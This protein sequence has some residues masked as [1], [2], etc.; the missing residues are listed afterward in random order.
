LFDGAAW[1]SFGAGASATFRHAETAREWTLI[2][3][4]RMR[5]CRGGEEQVAIASGRLRTT[6]GAGAR[7]GAEVLVFTPHGVLRYGDASLELTVERRELRTLA[8]GGQVWLETLEGKAAVLSLPL[9]KPQSTKGKRPPAS[10]EQRCE[11]LAQRASEV[12]GALTSVP[13]AGPGLSARAVE[14][15]RARRDARFACGA[16]EAFAGGLEP[17]ERGR[18]LD[19]LVELERLYRELP[20]RPTAPNP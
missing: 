6:T 17:P 11:T 9:G 20:R 8:K 14:H 18:L 4:G 1:L 16:A 10:L 12:G 13:S 15:L 2:G 3:P 19:R 5:P 7:P